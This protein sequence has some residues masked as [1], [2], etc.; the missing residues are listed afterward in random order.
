MRLPLGALTLGG[1]KPLSLT[2]VPYFHNNG[3]VDR[4]NVLAALA[5]LAQDSRLDIFRLL[6]EQSPEG[7]SAGAIAERLGLANPTLSFHL[8]GLAH[9]KLVAARQE[10]RFI[11]YSA[12]F[13]TM[14]G[15]MEYLTHNCCLGVTCDISCAPVI[16]R[17]RRSS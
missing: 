16:Q 17:K 6:V 2:T 7:L 14:N 1:R 9:A 4:K 11:Y 10:G 13:R 12:N 15:L 5:G 8:K 3:N